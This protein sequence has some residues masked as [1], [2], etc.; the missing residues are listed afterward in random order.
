MI[1]AHTARIC[2]SGHPA[3]P[4]PCHRACPDTGIQSTN[5]LVLTVP[6]SAEKGPRMRGHYPPSGV[7]TFVGVQV[8]D[9][10]QPALGRKKLI[11]CSGAVARR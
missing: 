6:R 4:V 1:G 10:D 7:S 5:S 3:G 8:P 2:A 11:A 9:P